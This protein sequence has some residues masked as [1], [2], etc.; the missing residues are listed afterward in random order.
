MILE[1]LPAVM[2]LSPRERAQLAKELWEEWLP[3]DD[4]ESHSAIVEVL[5]SRAA[6]FREQPESAS[7]WDEVKQRLELLRKCRQ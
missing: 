2:N 7:S 3:R 6:H 1:T 4:S 5:E